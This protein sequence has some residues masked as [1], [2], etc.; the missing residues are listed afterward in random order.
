MN[1]FSDDDQKLISFLRE[2]RSLPT[3]P[4]AELEEKIFQ[5]IQ[6]PPKTSPRGNYQLYLTIPSAIAAGLLFSWTSYRWLNFSPEIAT[7]HEEIETFLMNSWNSTIED[8][9]SDVNSLERNWSLLTTIEPSY[10]DTV[11]QKL[12]LCY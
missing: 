1:Q 10:P 5:K 2:Y 8:P 7:N 9:S 6:T 11:T 4:D 3:T 12:L